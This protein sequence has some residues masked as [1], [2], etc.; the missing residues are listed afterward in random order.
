MCLPCRNYLRAIAVWIAGVSLIAT[1]ATAQVPSGTGATNLPA[2]GTKGAWYLS[3]TNF[4]A[5]VLAQ[6]ERIQV[7]EL[8]FEA[9]RRRAKAE[10]GIFEPALT[11]GATHEENKRQLTGERLVSL[12]SSASVLTN[13]SEQNN[14][15]NSALE[16]L[17]PTGARLR[18]GANLSQLENNF[19]R[20]ANTAF[21]NGEYE[22]F[23]GASLVQP[24]LKNFGPSA[25]LANLRIAS[26][27]SEIAWHD[28]RK[29]ISQTLAGAE[30]GYWGLYLAQEQVRFFDES[31][32]V[33][34]TVLSD[35][36]ARNAAG[37][38]AEIDILQAE[39]DLAM[40]RNGRNEA[41]QKLSEARSRTAGFIDSTELDARG[42]IVA[43]APPPVAD[44]NL[45]FI[46][47]W[48]WVFTQNPD[49]AAQ[50]ARLEQEG[51]RVAFA[52]NQRLPQLDLKASYGLNGL[53]RNAGDSL[54]RFNHQAYESWSFGVEMRIPLGGGIKERNEYAA[55]QLRRRAALLTLKELETTLRNTLN[56]TLEKVRHAK[57]SIADYEAAVKLNENLLKTELARLEV[58]RVEA[59]KVL[60]V[61]RDL[62]QSRLSALAAVV[63]Y[64]QST[65]ELDVLSGTFLSRRN[66]S[67]SRAEVADKTRSIMNRTAD[68]TGAAH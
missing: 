64:H 37:K 2:A 34:E 62:L 13:F 43:A 18:L 56:T 52:K 20:F 36:R 10:A 45:D 46:E 6:N 68:A 11:L 15:F 67:L 40:R 24:L 47:Q 53:G 3:P 59:R 32:K 33:A 51:I 63:T 48:S 39:A 50:R 1:L 16:F 58:G 23:S 66:L 19:Q 25:T 17:V 26:Q 29:Q 4:L 57:G 35:A 28:Y 9:T 61:E 27:Q 42:I 65:L 22:S 8:E 60:E 30:A 44:R 49:F 31:V 21:T 14:R 54:E 12:G 41:L 7:Q 5:L 38:A 55:A